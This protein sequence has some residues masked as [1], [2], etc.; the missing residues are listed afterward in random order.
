MDIEGDGTFRIRITHR[1]VDR[2]RVEV[3]EIDPLK[4]RNSNGATALEHAITD[5]ST[6]GHRSIATR[7]HRNPVGW[8]DHDQRSHRG[9]YRQNDDGENHGDYQQVLHNMCSFLGAEFAQ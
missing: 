1:D 3:H 6:V 8:T 9:S 7:D 5:I 4:D 2:D